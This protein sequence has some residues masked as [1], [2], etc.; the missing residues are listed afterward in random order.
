MRKAALQKEIE[1][2]RHKLVAMRDQAEARQEQ[3]TSEVAAKI[4]TLRVQTQQVSDRQ[5][6]KTEKRI[7]EIEADYEARRVKLDQAQKLIQEVL[8]P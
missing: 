3:A 1:D 4:D 6:A 5:K 8:F 7:A 2:V